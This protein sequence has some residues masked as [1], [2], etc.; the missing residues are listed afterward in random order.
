MQKN[1]PAKS[2]KQAVLSF[3]EALGNQ[4]YESAR[5]FVSDSMSFRGPLASY[6][7]AETYFRDVERLRLP[8]FEIKKVFADGNDVCLLYDLNV[9]TTPAPVFVCG[10]YHVGD[11]GKISSLKV[12]FDPRP[13]LQQ[14][15][16]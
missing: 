6:D 4:D 1:E 13:F 14:M 15:Q 16:K 5:S 11:D 8:K 9:G 12:V 7:S 10:W 3:V 2:A